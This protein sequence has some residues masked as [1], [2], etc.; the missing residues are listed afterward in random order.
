M[1]NL[2]NSPAEIWPLSEFLALP[3]PKSTSFRFNCMCSH[4]RQG[5][6]KYPQ[7]FMVCAHQMYLSRVPNCYYLMRKPEALA[8]AC[9]LFRTCI[10]G[11][12]TRYIHPLPLICLFCSPICSRLI[13]KYVCVALLSWLKFNKIRGCVAS[14]RKNVPTEQSPSIM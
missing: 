11:P 2:H 7:S 14:N 13:H 10:E 1:I 12:T 6:K 5:K 8:L 4:F 9:F 3:T